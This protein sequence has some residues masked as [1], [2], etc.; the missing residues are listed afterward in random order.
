MLN[1]ITVYLLDFL[2]HFD[3]AYYG[4]HSYPVQWGIISSTPGALFATCLIISLLLFLATMD[5]V[6]VMLQDSSI[7]TVLAHM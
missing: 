7:F 4:G 5:I 6:V 1:V 3:L 2:L